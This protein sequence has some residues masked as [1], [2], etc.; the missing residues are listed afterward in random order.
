MNVVMQKTSGDGHRVWGPGK[1]VYVETL[2]CNLEH[3][4]DSYEKEQQKN[5][6]GR[7]KASR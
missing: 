6:L 3:R 1:A 4:G 2:W 5:G 7:Q